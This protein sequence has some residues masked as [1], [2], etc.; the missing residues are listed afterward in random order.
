MVHGWFYV[1]ALDLLISISS[2]IVAFSFLATRPQIWKP[3]GLPRFMHHGMDLWRLLR[4]F[5]VGSVHNWAESAPKLCRNCQN[6]MRRRFRARLSQTG[7]KPATHFAHP[8][9]EP[10]CPD[11]SSE[12]PLRAVGLGHVRSPLSHQAYRIHNVL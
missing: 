11:S 9:S 1:S 8:T 3:P 4:S 12:P 2:P 10:R 7:P 6:K 5:M